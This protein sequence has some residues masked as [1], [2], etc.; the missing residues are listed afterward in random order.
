MEMYTFFQVEKEYNL[1]YIKRFS[2]D[3]NKSI[4]FQN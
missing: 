3:V 1:K 4:P 2:S